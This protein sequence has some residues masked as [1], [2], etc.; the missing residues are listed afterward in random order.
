MRI[1]LH[2]LFEAD[3][4]IFCPTVLFCGQRFTDCAGGSKTSPENLPDPALNCTSLHSINTP[5]LDAEPLTADMS[6]LDLLSRPL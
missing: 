3:D 4:P 1:S 6:S 2:Y 5:F